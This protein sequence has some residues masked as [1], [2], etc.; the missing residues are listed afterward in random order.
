MIYNFV[1]YERALLAAVNQYGE[2]WVS[3]A[4]I[5]EFVGL[6]IILPK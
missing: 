1:T 4:V 3:K 2:D 6:W 5:K